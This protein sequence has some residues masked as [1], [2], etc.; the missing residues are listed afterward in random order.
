VPEAVAAFEAHRAYLAGSGEGLRRRAV[1][2]RSRLLA[3]LEDRF[4][5]AVE[6]RA[7]EPD[8]LEE[9]VRAVGERREDP[10]TAAGRLFDGLVRGA[11]EAAARGP[12]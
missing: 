8:G 3:L 9:A 10:Y 1:R 7:P 4:R 12:A 2:A 11:R 5:R 6:A